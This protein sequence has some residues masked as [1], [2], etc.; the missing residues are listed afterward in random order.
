[1]QETSAN[2]PGFITL[3]TNLSESHQTSVLQHLRAHGITAFLTEA[4]EPS[5]LVLPR[6]QA[7]AKEI[8]RSVVQSG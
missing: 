7:Q 2:T 8:L 5:I 3:A 4:A 1:M 6:N